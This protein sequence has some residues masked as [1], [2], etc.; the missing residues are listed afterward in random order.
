MKNFILYI[1]FLSLLSSCQSAGF[2]LKEEVSDEFLV[3]KKNPLVMPPDYENLPKPV[4]FNKTRV[5]KDEFQKIINNNIIT[6]KNTENTS[7]E[8]SIIEKLISFNVEK[9]FST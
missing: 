5:E 4:L 7:L 8:K 2:T 9:N 3:E 6:E 1:L